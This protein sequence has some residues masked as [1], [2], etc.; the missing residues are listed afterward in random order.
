MRAGFGAIVGLPS[1]ASSLHMEPAA[2]GR[3]EEGLR[4]PLTLDGGGAVP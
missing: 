2:P 3:A 1:K 4:N